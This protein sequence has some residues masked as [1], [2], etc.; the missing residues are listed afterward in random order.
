MQ[1]IEAQ[2]AMRNYEGFIRTP[3][4]PAGAGAS[5]TGAGRYAAGRRA[6]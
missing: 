5:Q 3:S 4:G 6:A 1:A 2:M